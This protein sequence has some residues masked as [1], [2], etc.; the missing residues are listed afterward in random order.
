MML[1]ALIYDVDGLLKSFNERGS[2]SFFDFGQCFIDLEFPTIF[3]GRY[4]TSELVEVSPYIGLL[5]N[6]LF[7]F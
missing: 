3:L 2:N 1:S 6:S 4:S 5:F 7:L